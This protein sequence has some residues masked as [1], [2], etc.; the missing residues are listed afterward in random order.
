M[1]LLSHSW[2]WN[3]LSCWHHLDGCSFPEM[4]FLQ[5]WVCLFVRGTYAQPGL[6][7]I[8]TCLFIALGEKIGQNSRLSPN[9]FFYRNIFVRVTSTGSRTDQS[10]SSKP[11]GQRMRACVHANYLSV[12]LRERQRGLCETIPGEFDKLKKSVWKP[13]MHGTKSSTTLVFHKTR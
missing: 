10:A 7:L 11:S 4:W 5:I 2:F 8:H 1:L 6:M 9:F 13:T 12:Y 3:G